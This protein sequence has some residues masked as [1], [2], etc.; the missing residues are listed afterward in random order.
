MK[1]GFRRWTAAVLLFVF[2]CNFLQVSKFNVAASEIEHKIEIPL[3]KPAVPE[4]KLLSGEV[5]SVLSSVSQ[6][7]NTITLSGAAGAGYD[8]STVAE[9]I[10]KM[11]S[12]MA[13]IKSS[14]GIKGAAAV[15]EV[16][17]INNAIDDCY[18]KPLLEEVYMLE[19]YV[20]LEE[21]MAGAYTGFFD[22]QAGSPNTGNMECRE[23]EILGYDFLLTDESYDGNK[24][25]YNR[26]SSDSAISKETAVMDIYKALGIEI[27]QIQLYC[28]PRE[29]VDMINSPAV[30]GLPW[31][32][33]DIDA[34]RGRTDAFIT[35]TVPKAY[36]GKAQ[37]ELHW[38]SS[39]VSPTEVITLGEFIVRVADM[40]D[41]YGE[42][43]ISDAEMNTLLQVFGGKIPT[44]LSG[45]QLEAYI[46]LRS[47]GILTDE[48]QV[49][50]SALTFKQMIEILMRVKDVDSRQDLKDIQITMDVSDSLVNAGF[51]PKT[52]TVADGDSAIH[53]KEDYNYM[54]VTTYDYFIDMTGSGFSAGETPYIPVDLNNP[55]GST[56]FNGASIDGYKT[57]DGRQYLHIRINA[58]S[59]TDYFSSVQALTG[60]NPAFMLVDKNNPDRKLAFLQGGGVYNVT[61]S[62]NGVTLTDRA[63]F[64]KAQGSWQ[65]YV[66]YERSQAGGSDS[67]LLSWIK[68]IFTPMTVAAADSVDDVEVTMTVFNWSNVDQDPNINSQEQLDI[69]AQVQVDLI[70]D[71]AMLRMS[72]SQTATF[73]QNIK[74]RTD[75]GSSGSR[76]VQGI[77]S[78]SGSTLVPLQGFIDNGLVYEPDVWDLSD[79][80]VLDTKYGRVTLNQTMCTVLAGTTLYKLS[81]G[82]QLFAIS[83]E[84]ND[85]LVDFRAVYG[86]SSTIADITITGTGESFNV[87]VSQFDENNKTA[88]VVTSYIK[89]TDYFDNDASSAGSRN[90]LFIPENIITENPGYMMTSNY[91]LANWLTIDSYNPNENALYV[92]Y[93]RK[94]FI[95]AQMAVPNDQA[96]VADI[97]RYMGYKTAEMN[98]WVIRKF[99]LDFLSH[100]EAGRV[101]Y[102]EDY[103]YIYNLPTYDDFTYEKY[104]NG[105]Y[106][107]PLY[108]RP[109]PAVST[110]GPQIRNANV[111]IWDTLPQGT[112]VYGK[113]SST[114]EPK[115]LTVDWKGNIGQFTGNAREVVNAVPAGVQ[116]LFSGV[117]LQYADADAYTE[118]LTSVSQGGRVAV[119]FGTSQMSV[120]SDSSKANIVINNSFPGRNR[121]GIEYRCEFTLGEDTKFYEIARWKLNASDKNWQS[122]YVH[123]GSVL[124]EKTVE[125][126]Q[127]DS[128]ELQRNPIQIITEEY[129][130]GF[131]DFDEF[132]FEY[133][134]HQVDT[135][136]YWILYIAVKILPMFMIV[137][138]TI[139]MGISFMNDNKI[140]QLIVDKTFDPVKFLTFGHMTFR[141]LSK[142]QCLMTLMIGYIMF[143]L[144]V[145][146]NIIKVIMFVSR[147]LDI[148]AQML[149]NV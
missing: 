74:R 121:G 141:K 20:M 22:L 122:M 80:L 3:I 75:T 89:M 41:L 54:N 29:K 42:P 144:I 7:S 46:Y 101:S 11:Q 108:Y 34:S 97:Q 140:V 106:F 55:E 38:S 70:N 12:D 110:Y 102:I 35:R 125:E 92:F 47:R 129:K 96:V 18:Y 105:E 67:G 114:G 45:A 26:L 93:H 119:Y 116:S 21:N 95:N 134:L 142:K 103:G 39:D 4:I 86:W 33:N 13:G 66:D 56:G 53:I 94:A 27:Q 123:F 131:G 51:F 107:L 143:T 83:K 32:V 69:Y 60:Q 6:S 10:Q 139:V 1:A 23:L 24:Y 72:K 5:T 52:I 19:E 57:I 147:F 30:K 31:L 65:G 68:N 149:R 136:S 98:D 90:A 118:L 111:N 104:L 8:F 14:M 62:I 137:A 36:A 16:F 17:S 58:A 48:Y 84:T 28:N 138:L 145:D 78:I 73:R 49:F 50:S 117:S 127:Q 59:A 2:F 99:P 109:N 126:I 9:G 135:F 133:L 113:E 25:Q 148:T 71:T 61:G 79:V 43:V 115:T 120:N 146:G 132:S 124:E 112:R 88:Q 44:S 128:E 82:T 64:D 77:A 76:A 130:E 81:P 37:R 63:T 87:S 85:V 15:T 40:M 91:K 100:N